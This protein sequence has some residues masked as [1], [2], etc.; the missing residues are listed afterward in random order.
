MHCQHFFHCAQYSVLLCTVVDG[1]DTRNEPL[2]IQLYSEQY[3]VYSAHFRVR[4][5][6]HTTNRIGCTLKVF[7]IEDALYKVFTFED[8]HYRLHGAL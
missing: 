6:E 7:T 4:K 8:A 2:C 1:L 5:T 3:R